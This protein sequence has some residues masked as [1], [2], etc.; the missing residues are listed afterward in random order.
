MQ[1]SVQNRWFLQTQTHDEIPHLESTETTDGKKINRRLTDISRRNTVSTSLM[2][3]DVNI[4]KDKGAENS[5]HNGFPSLSAP[6]W[7]AQTEEI[8]PLSYLLL[9]NRGITNDMNYQRSLPDSDTSREVIRGEINVPCFV[10]NEI[11][12]IYVCG[13]Y[14]GTA[15]RL[16]SLC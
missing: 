16:G 3:S 1:R 15:K 9:Q 5:A 2:L 4:S 14:Q 13:G 12:M 7:K 6:H 10:R 8:N 11:F